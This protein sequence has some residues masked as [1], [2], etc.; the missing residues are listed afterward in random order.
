[1]SYSVFLAGQHE[2][3]NLQNLWEMAYWLSYDLQVSGTLVQ[4]YED[5]QAA[6]CSR[7]LQ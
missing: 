3:K 2:L 7:V 1:M 5:L 4:G 6:L